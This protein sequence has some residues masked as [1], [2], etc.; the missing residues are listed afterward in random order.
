MAIPVVNHNLTKN[1]LRNQINS[2]LKPAKRVMDEKLYSQPNPK[3][4][5]DT[6]MYKIFDSLKYMIR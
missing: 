4:L 5:E 3:R 6:D 1:S 2:A